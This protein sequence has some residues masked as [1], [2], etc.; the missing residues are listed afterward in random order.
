MKPQTIGRVLG[1]GMRV[2]GRFAS[3]RLAGT[4][5]GQAGPGGPVG[6]RPV[7]IQG[8]MGPVDPRV[9]GRK[10]GKATG[11]VARGVGAFLRPF[12]QVGG[13]LWLEVTG[14]FFLLPVV[15]FCPTVWHTKASY[16][17]GP[18]HRTFLVSIAV[19]VVFLYL[20]LSS[21]WRAWRK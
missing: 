15:V 5:S 16:L 7:T 10:T 14:V 4:A 20:G 8:V 19:V 12:R 9:A 11:S 6:S 1:I 17:H 13:K 3:Q 2:A 21:F 18:D